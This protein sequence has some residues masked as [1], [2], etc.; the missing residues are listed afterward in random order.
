MVGQGGVNGC[1]AAAVVLG[2]YLLNRE[3][4]DKNRPFQNRKIGLLERV[5]S[6]FTDR[7]SPRWIRAGSGC[8]R[9]GRW[10]AS[11]PGACGW[12]SVPPIQYADSHSVEN[13]RCSRIGRCGFSVGVKPQHASGV[14]TAPGNSPD[15]GVAV[16]GE[17]ER[18]PTVPP[19]NI[20][21]LRD[22]TCQLK[23]AVDFRN[24]LSPRVGV[25]VRT[26]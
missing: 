18:E 9:L 15:R 3:L 4:S 26:S 19:G 23:R 5:A 20:N 12:N 11:A 2:L 7:R 17:H 13:A 21:R 22:H 25:S 14:A 6:C 10:C 24:E 16:F 1:N 8:S